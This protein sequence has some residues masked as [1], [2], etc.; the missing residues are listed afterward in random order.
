MTARAGSKPDI[1]PR[2]REVRS[3]FFLAAIVLGL[4]IRLATI[5]LPGNDDVFVWKLWSYAATN[6]LTGMYGVGG[7]PHIDA[8]SARASLT[9]DLLVIL[10]RI[11]VHE[12]AGIVDRDVAR[13]GD[14]GTDDRLGAANLIEK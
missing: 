4:L 14:V 11:D 10:R 5:P 2:I 3:G 6:D 7:T 13:G 12:R 9:A 1:R 8:A